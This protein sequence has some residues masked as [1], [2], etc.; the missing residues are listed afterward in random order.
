VLEGGLA[1]AVVVPEAFRQLV[2]GIGAGALGAAD[3]QH[4]V[5]E[6]QHVSAFEAQGRPDLALQ[7]RRDLIEDPCALGQVAQALVMA[8]HVGKDQGFPLPGPGGHGVHGI[9]I[10]QHRSGIPHEEQVGDGPQAV[11]EAPLP[12]GTFRG[13][14]P[15][16]AGDDAASAIR[17]AHVPQQVAGG[18]RK[19]HQAAEILDEGQLHAFLGQGFDE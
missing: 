11:F 15:G 2:D 8:E 17:R 1:S 12:V 13:V 7:E 16:D 3:G 6:H 9:D 10:P 5:A 18:I 19:V 4:L 14:L